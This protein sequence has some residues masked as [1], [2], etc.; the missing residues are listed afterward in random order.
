[1]I[2]SGLIGGVIAGLT[3]AISAYLFFDFG[4]IAAFGIY[5][6]CGVIVTLAILTNGLLPDLHLPQKPQ[7]ATTTAT[8]S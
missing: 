1:M 5:I 6:L 8:H 4:I 7:K 2:L 3:A